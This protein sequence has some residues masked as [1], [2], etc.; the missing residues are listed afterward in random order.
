MRVIAFYR[1]GNTDNNV[2]KYHVNNKKIPLN[3]CRV[4]SLK[5]MG[6][7]SSYL[8]ETALKR[9]GQMLISTFIDINIQ[10]IIA[11]NKT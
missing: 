8:S 10:Q 2:S 11:V 9:T 3:L 4:P 7:L 5:R 1:N 6:T